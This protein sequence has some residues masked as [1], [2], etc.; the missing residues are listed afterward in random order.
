MKKAQIIREIETIDNERGHWFN[1]HYRFGI[2]FYYGKLEKYN[3]TKLTGIL[4]NLKR[5]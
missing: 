5:C 3:K 1:E 4:N 2:K